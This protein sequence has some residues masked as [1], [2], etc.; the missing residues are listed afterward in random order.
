MDAL[1][2]E[3][4]EKQEKEKKLEDAKK[5][6][7]VMKR[8]RKAL[9]EREERITE[10]INSGNMEK[11]L[12]TRLPLSVISSDSAQ[13]QSQKNI[14]KFSQEDVARL[15]RLAKLKL[16][17]KATA[18]CL[19]ITCIRDEANDEVKYM[20]D[21]YI[22]GKPY[23][24]YCLRV[25]YSRGILLRGHSLPNAVPVNQLFEKHIQ[26]DDQREQAAKME[27]F[28]NDLS[29]HL[30]AFLSRQKQLDDLRKTFNDDLKNCNAL[31]HCTA[32][33]FTL[34]IDDESGDNMSCSI[35]MLY[36]KNQERPKPGSVRILF[37]PVLEDEVQERY[38]ELAQIFYKK[39]L[40][41]A[42]EELF[43]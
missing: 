10:A 33:S 26:I 17:L 22:E 19:G 16:K 4:G 40:C 38:D 36:N 23:G 7:R 9:M 8:K 1:L 5:E 18:M 41:D 15:Q 28:L 6:I 31:N 35:S 27:S 21:P 14:Q 11:D 25:R 2:L 32:I 30:R 43:L 42:V 29:R 20:F 34:C 12:D 13:R 3:Y 39:S 37:D 24:P